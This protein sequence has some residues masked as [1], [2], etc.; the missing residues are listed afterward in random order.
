MGGAK[1]SRGRGTVIKMY[2][3]RKEPDFNKRRGKR[4]TSEVSALNSLLKRGDFGDTREG[5]S[6]KF[7]FKY[8]I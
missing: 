8:T 4:S 5:P 2:C 7:F 6:D 1:R 3:M